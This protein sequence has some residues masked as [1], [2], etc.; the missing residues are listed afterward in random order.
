M[1]CR[2]LRLLSLLGI[3][4]IQFIKADIA[5]K[6]IIIVFRD[7][8]GHKSPEK[9]AQLQRA[10]GCRVLFDGDCRPEYGTTAVLRVATGGKTLA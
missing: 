10:M 6:I 8:I 7:R 4:F 2:A 9:V 3:F 5:L 1:P